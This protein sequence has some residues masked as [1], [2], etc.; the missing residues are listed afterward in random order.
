MMYTFVISLI[1]K[2][3][4]FVETTKLIISNSVRVDRYICEIF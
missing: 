2:P 4:Y 3:F 1:E